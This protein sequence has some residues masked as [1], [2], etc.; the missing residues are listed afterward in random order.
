MIDWFSLKV[1]KK[2]ESEV[3]ACCL[4]VV[5]RKQAA[6]KEEK[7]KAMRGQMGNLKSRGLHFQHFYAHEHANQRWNPIGWRHI[8]QRGFWGFLVCTTAS[9]LTICLHSKSS[10]ARRRT[11]DSLFHGTRANPV[12]RGHNLI[13]SIPFFDLV[14]ILEEK[15]DM[16][17]KMKE[18]RQ[19]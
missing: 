9:S 19:R 15:Q 2:T 6:D 4:F 3:N 14:Y 10:K 18:Q 11:K 13:F 5:P 1:T 17:M 8:A 7:S 12:G 16:E